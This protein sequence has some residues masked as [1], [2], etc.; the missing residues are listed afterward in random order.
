[1][2]KDRGS[3]YAIYK[4]G[5]HKGNERGRSAVDAIKAYVIASDLESFIKDKKFMKQYF[6]TIA[7]NGVHHHHLITTKK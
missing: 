6:A 5:E 2:K 7:I 3:L 4:N 1:M